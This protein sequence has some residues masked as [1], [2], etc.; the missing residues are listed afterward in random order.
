MHS[1]KDHCKT[2][3]R[4]ALLKALRIKGIYVLPFVRFLKR[5]KNNKI[6]QKILAGKITVYEFAELKLTG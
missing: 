4:R 3:G 2:S 1:G 6:Q 5:F